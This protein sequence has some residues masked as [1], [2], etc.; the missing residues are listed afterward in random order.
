MA[1]HA[2]KLR[3]RIDAAVYTSRDQ[4]RNAS[5]RIAFDRVDPIKGDTQHDQRFACPGSSSI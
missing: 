1:C 3:A 4:N 2:V 5:E